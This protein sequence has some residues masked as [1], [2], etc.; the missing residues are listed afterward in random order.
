MD[1]PKDPVWR[2]WRSPQKVIGEIVAHD[3]DWHVR[4]LVLIY[5]AVASFGMVQY[6]FSDEDIMLNFG[7]LPS[8]LA[9]FLASYALIM[10]ALPRVLVLLGRPFGGMAGFRQTR[11]VVAWSMLG[12]IGAGLCSMAIFLASLLSPNILG[13]SMAMT[14]AALLFSVGGLIILVCGLQKINGYSLKMVSVVAV[15]SWFAVAVPFL[16]L[17]ILLVSYGP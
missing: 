14:G 12:D 10:H 8:M 2:I 16:F 17:N 6:H 15:M 5:S 11:A 7:L 4:E 1:A 3:P 9:V 13:I